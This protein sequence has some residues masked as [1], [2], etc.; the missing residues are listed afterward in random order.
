M[1]RMII[2]DDERIIRETIHNLIDWSK[3]NIEVVGLCRDGIEA[4]DMIIDEY[5]DIVLTDIKM[6]G[7]SG[8]ELIKRITKSKLNIQFI[9][10][11]GYGEFSFAK[12]AMKYG[13][14]HYLL[15][16]CNE[17]QIIE[18][19]N[20]AIEDCSKKI[21]FQE[22]EEKHQVLSKNFYENI[23]RNILTENLSTT[24]SLS[25]LTSQ[26]ERFLDFS[27][28]EYELCYLYYLQEQSLTNYLTQIYAYNTTY[29][30]NIPI[31][32]VYVTNTL[33]LFFENYHSDLTQFDLFISNIKL[34]NQEIAIEYNR[35]KQDNLYSLLSPLITKLKRYET[36]YLMN[37]L[38]KIKTSNHDTLLQSMDRIAN[39]LEH[40]SEAENSILKNE[41]K[42]SLMTVLDADFLKTLI[43]NLLL[44]D[45]VINPSYGKSSIYISEFLVQISQLEDVT[46]IMRLFL[47]NMDSLFK[48][49]TAPNKCKDFIEKTLCYVN[50]NISDPNLSL[51]WISENYLFMNVDYV[52]KQ[53]VKQTGTKFSSYLANARIDLAKKLLIERGT[54]KIYAIAE[55]I[56]CGNNPQYFSQLFK[57]HTGITPTT[58]VKNM[59]GN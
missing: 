49:P 10:L 31:Y 35:T 27:N 40:A 38:H 57:K 5:P 13:V 59:T 15:K 36:V 51:K 19:I 34:D 17:G 24:V 3:L 58:Y 29:A 18:V 14:K 53:F 2:V 44:K 42:E 8:L 4:Y 48:L 37:G 32:A 55:E 52:S 39:L 21:A 47:D 26:Y 9:I 20:E 33:I 45:A 30:P 41:I 43:T 23:V 25:S 46:Q 28:T 1:L 22:L 56:G 54:D 6:P 12:E 16:P 50:E 11:S 7:L